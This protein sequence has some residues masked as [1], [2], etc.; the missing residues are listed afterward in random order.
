MIRIH[1][2]DWRIHLKDPTE[3]E[4]WFGVVPEETSPTTEVR[5][6]LMGPRCR[7]ASTVEVAYSLRATAGNPLGLPGIVRRAIIP[8]ASQWE[9]THPFLYQGPVE[10][11]DEGRLCGERMVS[12]GVRYLHLGTRG[13]RLNGRLLQLRGVRR[14]QC[15]AEEMSELREEGVNLL[16]ANVDDASAQLWTDAD[17]VGMLVLGEVPA[18][19]SAIEQA[20]ARQHHPSNLGWVFDASMLTDAGLRAASAPLRERRAG[21]ILG[22]HATVEMPPA[23]EVQFIVGTPDMGR[24]LPRLLLTADAVEETSGLLGTVRP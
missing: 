24:D 9:P 12:C 11:W 22:I 2:L 5:G 14:H 15:T 18:S 10:L 7:Y 6:R 19:P 17:E 16:L 21:E 3:P 23:P 8:E 20:R 1:E 13:L 4:I